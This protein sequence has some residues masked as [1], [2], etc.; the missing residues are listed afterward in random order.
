MGRDRRLS[1]TAKFRSV[2]YPNLTGGSGLQVRA[3]P[4]RDRPGTTIA[5]PRVVDINRQ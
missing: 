2:K 4:R 1:G 3:V 5:L